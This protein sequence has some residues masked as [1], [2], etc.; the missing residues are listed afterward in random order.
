MAR[1]LIIEDD[2][3][4]RTMLKEM[5]TRQEYEVIEA[6]NGVE[7]LEAYKTQKI[8]LVVTDIFMP[9]KEGTETVMELQD[10]NPDIKVIAISGGGT[11]KMFEQL[12]WMKDFGAQKVFKKPFDSKEFLAAVS[13]LLEYE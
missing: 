10:M 12:N 8:D 2:E 9:E 4:F 3:D 13:N 5:L 7:G 1:I 11:Q 6:S